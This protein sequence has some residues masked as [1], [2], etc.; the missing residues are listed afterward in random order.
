M[1]RMKPRCPKHPEQV[2]ICPKCHGRKGGKATAKLHPEKL[3]EWGK[4]GGRPRKSPEKE[5]Q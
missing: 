3:R 4:L 5:N 2:L 1:W